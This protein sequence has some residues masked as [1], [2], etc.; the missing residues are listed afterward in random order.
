MI[1]LLPFVSEKIWGYEHWVLSTCPGGLS[2][3][4]GPPPVR[5]LDLLGREHPLLVKVIQ[6]DSGLSVQVHPGDAYARARES[7]MGKSECWYV[8][9][10]RPGADL[11]TGLKPGVTGE[12]VRRGVAEH[13]LEPLLWHERVGP[14]DLV[15]IPAGTVHTIGGGLRLL[16][17]QQASDITYRLYDWG[18][19]RDLQV[20]KALEVLLPDRAPVI[21]GFSGRFDG[22]PYFS[23]EVCG[24]GTLRFAA[25]DVLFVQSGTGAITTKNRPV[26]AQAEDTFLCVEPETL[27]IAEGLRCLKIHSTGKN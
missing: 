12:D 16:E 14:G 2:F 4:E 21:R 19:G 6:A 7:S 20:Q 13:R 5:L 18:R 15:Y 10:A 17:V 26:Q 24:H 22:C 9:A 1:R 8:L 11:V 23:L 25:T 3:A 27:H